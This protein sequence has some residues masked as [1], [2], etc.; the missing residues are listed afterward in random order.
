MQ[1]IN[2]ISRIIRVT[3]NIASNKLPSSYLRKLKEQKY[4][5]ITIIYLTYY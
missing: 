5:E 4:N 3:S 2:N 1:M